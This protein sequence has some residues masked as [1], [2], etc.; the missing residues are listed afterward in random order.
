[1][2]CTVSD[3]NEFP[4]KCKSKTN[5]SNGRKLP[6]KQRFLNVFRRKS[7]K[8]GPLKVESSDEHTGQQAEEQNDIDCD[9]ASEENLNDKPSG[10]VNENTM[11]TSHDSAELQIPSRSK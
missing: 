5:G 3:I 8:V 9:L 11:L 10:C 1:M 6:L 7:N 4:G 2:H